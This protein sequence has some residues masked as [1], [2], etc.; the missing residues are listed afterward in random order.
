MTEVVWETDG[1]EELPEVKPV[2]F[3]DKVPAAPPVASKTPA[4]R[5]FIVHRKFHC[6]EYLQT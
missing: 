3:P 6:A 2:L 5:Y 1:V 4:E